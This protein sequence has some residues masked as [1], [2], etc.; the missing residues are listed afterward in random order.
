MSCISLLYVRLQMLKRVCC[1]KQYLSSH[2]AMLLNV[3]QC[4]HASRLA[5][6]GAPVA[7]HPGRV[8]HK[9]GAG[10]G[11][12]GGRTEAMDWRERAIVEFRVA[13]KEALRR[14]IAGIS[15]RFRAALRL[16]AAGKHVLMD[17]GW[18]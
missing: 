17:S 16:A 9:R 4:V 12:T 8:F 2:S 14:T 15:G 11:S 1:I 3:L 5:G 6:G 7:G 10:Q 18:Q 13:R